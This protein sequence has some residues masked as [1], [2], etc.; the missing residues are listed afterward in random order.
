MKYFKTYLTCAAGM[1]GIF[2]MAFFAKSGFSWIVG[3]GLLLFLLLI[4]TIQG[5]ITHKK[6]WLFTLLALSVSLITLLVMIV[7][8]YK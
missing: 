7:Q 3:A 1:I 6:E 8:K 5:E 4:R 2:V